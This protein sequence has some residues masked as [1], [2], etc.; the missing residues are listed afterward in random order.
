MGMGDE[1]LVVKRESLFTEEEFEGFLPAEQRDYI[2]RILSNVDYQVRTEELERDPS[3][4]QPIPYVWIVNPETKEVFAYRRAGKDGNYSESRLAGKWSCGLGGHIDK[5]DSENPIEG[6][7]MRE[8]QEEVSMPEYPTPR[9]VG[10]LNVSGGV[11]A[12][13][14]GVV[15]IAETTHPVS[16]GD[17][18]M[19]HGRFY[20]I[21]ELEE[22]FDNPD[23][24]V[25]DW[26]KASW[27]FVKEYLSKL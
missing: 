12:V 25:E 22:I 14:F 23:V 9:I 1:I 15:A 10:Y 20:P 17:D 6:A 11:N 3:W 5:A 26:T 21:S 2:S 13:H 18:E 8:L 27:P 16:K 19:E 24:I 7:M 4:Q